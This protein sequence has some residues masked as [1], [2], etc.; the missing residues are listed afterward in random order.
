MDQRRGNILKSIPADFDRTFPLF[1]GVNE[2]CQNVICSR[3]IQFCHT[4]NK[5]FV[6]SQA[7]NWCLNLINI[8][9]LECSRKC[10]FDFMTFSVL[11]S[12]FRMNAVVVSHPLNAWNSKTRCIT[13]SS[14]ISA[15]IDRFIAGD[16]ILFQSRKAVLEFQ[17]QSIVN[18]CIRRVDNNF[19]TIIL[20]SIKAMKYNATV[21]FFVRW[22]HWV[23]NRWFCCYSISVR[24]TD[25]MHWSAETNRISF[26]LRRS[27]YL[28]ILP[29]IILLDLL[30]SCYHHWI[31]KASSLL[32]FLWNTRSITFT[33]VLLGGNLFSAV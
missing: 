27:A 28:Y 13:L 29:T 20:G 4:W 14:C 18:I 1:G 11:I 23:Y 12:P 21:C 9:S 17:G 33:K 15:R 3:L 16:D 6:P 25:A 2:P 32:V 24:Q 10:G 31:Q 8:K 22:T 5:R 7:V 26:L 19:N 30:D